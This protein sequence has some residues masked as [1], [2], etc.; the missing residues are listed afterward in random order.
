MEY[1]SNV[2]ILFN[3][4]TCTLSYFIFIVRDGDSKIQDFLSYESRLVSYRGWPDRVKQKP[5]ELAE[6]GFFYCGKLL[7]FISLYDN[8]NNEG[9]KPVILCVFTRFSTRYREK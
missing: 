7:V 6:A 2:D 5:K 3:K 9:F 1:I 8:N 4:K